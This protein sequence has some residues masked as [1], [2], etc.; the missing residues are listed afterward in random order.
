MVFFR[1]A[2]LESCLIARRISHQLVSSPFELGLL[3]ANHSV[4]AMFSRTLRAGRV[5]IK[6]IARPTTRLLPT[7]SLQTSPTRKFPKYTNFGEEESPQPPPGSGNSGNKPNS[8]WGPL[9]RFDR[10]T[11]WAIVALVA[12]A[13]NLGFQ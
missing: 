5:P 3:G 9:A 10:A 4:R 12:A 1:C 2:G 11:R 8:P 6:P 13:V 7:R